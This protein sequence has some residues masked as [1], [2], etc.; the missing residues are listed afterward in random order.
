MV[1]LCRKWLGVI[2]LYFSD[3]HR[4]FFVMR[5]LTFSLRTNYIALVRCVS[6]RKLCN[7]SGPRAPRKLLLRLCNSHQQTGVSESTE[8]RVALAN[9]RTT[10]TDPF[11]LS[12]PHD[13]VSKDAVRIDSFTL[14]QPG[15]DH[16]TA[17]WAVPSIDKAIEEL[18]FSGARFF[19]RG[20]AVCRCKR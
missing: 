16:T 15:K 8:F 11:P 10:S 19:V 6:S 9:S 1:T 18:F 4:A 17:T 2:I 20:S 3:D 13:P 14:M 5:L 7:E 12:S